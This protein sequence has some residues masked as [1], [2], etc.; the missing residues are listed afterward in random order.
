MTLLFFA[1]I[2]YHNSINMK[3]GVNMAEK[4]DRKV[5]FQLRIDEAAHK[6]LKIIAPR[7]VRSIN[8]QMEYFILKGIEQY[9]KENGAISLE[10]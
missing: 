5:P 10:D 9:E 1:I 6:K 8:S 4:A 3:V 7:E 2:C